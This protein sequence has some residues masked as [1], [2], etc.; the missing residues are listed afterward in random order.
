MGVSVAAGLL[1]SAG[2]SAVD[3]CSSPH[4]CKNVSKINN[5]SYPIICEYKD[6]F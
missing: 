5:K 4:C 2:W 6:K 3:F 1:F